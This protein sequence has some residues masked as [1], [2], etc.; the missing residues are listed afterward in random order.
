MTTDAARHDI[1]RQRHEDATSRESR[2]RLEHEREVRLSQVAAIERTPQ[3]VTDEV[4]LAQLDTARSALEEVEA[5]LR[6]M[7]DGTY[8][9][10]DACQAPIPAGRLEILPHARFCV[11]CQRRRR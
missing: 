1:G 5:A 3:Y 7:N 9:L 6:R 11:T 4:M 10:C 2:R 8:G